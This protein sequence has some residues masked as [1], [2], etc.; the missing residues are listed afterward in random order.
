VPKTFDLAAVQAAL[1]DTGLDGWLFYDF[2][3]TDPIARSILDLDPAKVGTRRWFY[4]VPAAGEPRKL[5]HAIETRALDAVPGSKSIYLTWQSLDEG[6]ARLLGGAR[7]IAMNYSPNGDVPYVSKVDAGTLERVRSKGVEVVSSADLVQLFEAT[8]SDEQLE[9]HRRAAARLR[10]L[11]DEVFALVGARLRAGRTITERD[12]VDHVNAALRASHLV[13]DHDPIVGVNEHAADPHFE[14]AERRE[15]SAPIRR[16][17]LLLFDVWAKEDTPGA[18]YADITWCAFVGGEPP[19]E[20]VEVFNVVRRARDTA[21]ARADEAFRK[22]TELRGF[23]LDRAA[24]E[25]IEGAGYGDYFI[26][27]TGHSIHET[28]HGNGANLDDLETHDTRKLLPRTLFSVEP[29]IYLP[30]RFG[31]RSEVD[32]YHTGSGAEITGPPHQTELVRI[33]V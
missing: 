26:H 20:I 11:V 2:R 24:R 8:L 4:F 29:G 5:V 12:V 33:E 14:V 1:K 19:A 10:G 16:G 7:R 3:G 9:G 23:E 13:I 27:R 30:G 21:V 32:V 17:D 25:V 22:G 18:V 15:D 31:I 6:V 28:T